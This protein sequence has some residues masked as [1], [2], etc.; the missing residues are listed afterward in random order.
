MR[1]LGLLVSLLFCPVLLFSQTINDSTSSNLISDIDEIINSVQLKWNAPGLA[2]G[3]V[4][5]GK[6]IYKKGIGYRNIDTKEPVTTN[7]LFSIASSTKSFT[8][9]G[10]SLLVDDGKLTWETTVKQCIPWFE[11]KDPIA[12]QYS[13]IG[14]IL[15]HRT[16]LPGHEIMQIA[17]AK[18]HDRREIVKRLKY[19]DPSKEFRTT[20]QYQNQMYQVATVITEEIGGVKWEDFIR[21]RI[22]TPLEMQN[23]GF[24]GDRAIQEGE[25]KAIR[26]G[27]NEFGEIIIASSI[28]DFLIEISGSGSIYSNVDDLCNWLIFNLNKGKYNNKTVVSESS[29]A[30][31]Q[32]PQIIISGVVLP[33]LLQ[34]SYSLAWDVMVYRGHLLYNRPGGFIGITSQIAFLPMDDLG[35]VLLGNI[36]STT[37]HLIILFEL[38]DRILELEDIDWIDKLWGY[39]EMTKTQFIEQ[40]KPSPQPE[41]FEEPSLNLVKYCGKYSNDGYGTIN[42]VCK[43]DTLYIEYIDESELIHYDRDEFQAYQLFKYYHFYF[44][45]SD[46]DKVVSV[47]CKFEP[48]VDEIIFHKNN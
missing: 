36:Q 17:I 12:S 33:E 45:I 21:Q 6:V 31:L 40:L 24:A 30:S 1:N 34:H 48:A 11:L 10:L 35:I 44:E 42:I 13:T 4:K 19:L 47:K 2:V 37:A 14:D 29:I 5:D 43:N 8:S 28:N 41:V 26:Y 9:T 27:F 20:W 22:F 7:T 32:N 25:D 23:T 3:V 38:I 16:G 18:Q 15:C 39:E 46:E